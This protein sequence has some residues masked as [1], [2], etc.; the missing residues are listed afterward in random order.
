MLDVALKFAGQLGAVA[1]VLVFFTIM[2]LKPK[3]EDGDPD[4]DIHNLSYG[5]RGD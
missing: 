2:L 1:I 5:D 4:I 3:Y